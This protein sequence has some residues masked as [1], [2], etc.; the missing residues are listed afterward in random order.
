MMLSDLKIPARYPW[1]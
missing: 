1:R